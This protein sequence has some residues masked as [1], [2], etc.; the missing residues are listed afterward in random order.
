[1]ITDSSGLFFEEAWPE[2]SERLLRCLRAQGASPALAEDVVQETA[3]RALKRGIEFSTAEDLRRW[4]SVVAR[5]LLIDAHRRGRNLADAALPERAAPDKVDRIVEQRLLLEALQTAMARLSDED[6][7]AVLDPVAPG[8]S[9]QEAVKLN[10]RRFRARSRLREMV[11]GLLGIAGWL[12]ARARQRTSSG[13]LAAAS[14]LVVLVASFTLLMGGPSSRGSTSGARPVRMP[15][16]RASAEYSDAQAVVYHPSVSPLAPGGTRE[17]AS[18]SAPAPHRLPA[19]GVAVPVPGTESGWVRGRPKSATDHLAC[20]E[21][22]RT[23]A[24]CVDSPVTV[25]DPL[26]H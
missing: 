10:V 14:P 11:E 17:V 15:S 24:R 22:L 3:F 2:V 20:F 26:G 16:A 8:L 25:S 21:V 7:R 9:R 18:P 1:M 19:A 12:L 5:R 6:R 23:G 13:A 4:S